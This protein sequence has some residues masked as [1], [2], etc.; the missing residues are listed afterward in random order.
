MCPY[1]VVACFLQREQSNRDQGRNFNTFHNLALKVCILLYSN[2]S[3]RPALMHCRRGLHKG[4]NT[5]RQSYLEIFLK[6]GFLSLH[7]QVC[8]LTYKKEDFFSFFFFF[9]RFFLMWTIFEVFTEFV[10]ILLMFWFFWPRGMWDLSSLTRD[11]TRTSYIG[12]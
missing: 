4:M 11:Q 1:S 7:L 6:A 2:R 12:R 8:P 3:H 10:T 9:L 5:R